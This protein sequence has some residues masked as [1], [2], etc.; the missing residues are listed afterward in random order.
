MN[1]SVN[2]V[3]EMMGMLIN[4]M[5]KTT[6]QCTHTTNGY[7]VHF[8]YLIVLFAKLYFNKAEK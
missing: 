8:K 4:K 1:E 6:S 2:K 3:C 7:N 5:G